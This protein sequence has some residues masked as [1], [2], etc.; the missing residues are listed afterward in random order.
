MYKMYVLVLSIIFAISAQPMKAGLNVKPTPTKTT[1]PAKT[2]T[3]AST[4]TFDQDVRALL[5][6]TGVESEAEMMVQQMGSML[7]MRN[8]KIPDADIIALMKKVSTAGFINAVVPVYKKH[9]TQAEIKELL[10]FYNSPVAKK[11]AQKAQVISQESSP[12]AKAW[13]EKEGKKMKA[14]LEAKGYS[15]PTPQAAPKK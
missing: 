6:I 1:T 3:T 5:K 13:F 15:F 11:M 10:K 4:T 12:S 14:A 7:K 8:P 9:F 2:T